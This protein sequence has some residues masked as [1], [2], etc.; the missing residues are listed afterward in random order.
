[1]KKTSQFISALMTLVIGILF[2]ILKAE[3]VGICITVI[4]IALIVTAVLDLIK[5]SI[6]SGIVKAL[7][8]AAVLII[9]WLLLDLALVILGIVLLVYGILEIFKTIVAA[10][11]DKNSKALTIVLGLV[12]PVICVIA[13]VFLI[14]NTGSAITWTVIVAGILLIIDGALGVIRALTAKKDAQ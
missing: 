7:L 1:M 4:G 3:V 6:V 14:T 5:K 10:V 11:K 8:A 12:E 9:G 2:V 13:S